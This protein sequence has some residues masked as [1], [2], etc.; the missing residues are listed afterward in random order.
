[1]QI[2]ICLL[3]SIHGGGTP[4]GFS[5]AFFILFWLCGSEVKGT[6]TRL[7]AADSDWKPRVPASAPVAGT[8]NSTGVRTVDHLCPRVLCLA[9]CGRIPIVSYVDSFREE[10]LSHTTILSIEPVYVTTTNYNPKHL[11]LTLLWI[12][13]KEFSMSLNTAIFKPATLRHAFIT[14]PS[15][16]TNAARPTTTSRA[17]TTP[18]RTTTC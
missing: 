11:Q 10:T 6:V 17:H 5:F 4:G 14:S 16:T 8:S 2:F 18:R 1:M 3:S 9:T 15:T 12:Q 13:F 7:F